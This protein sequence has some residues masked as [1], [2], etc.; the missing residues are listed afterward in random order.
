MRDRNTAATIGTNNELT[1]EFINNN[2]KVNV[3]IEIGMTTRAMQKT[4]T[5]K[6]SFISSAKQSNART[7]AA[8]S[9]YGAM[10]SHCSQKDGFVMDF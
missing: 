2:N 3:C 8:L 1:L 6:I 9:N 10:S 5:R 7:Q 4:T